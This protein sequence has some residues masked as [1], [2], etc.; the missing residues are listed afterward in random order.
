[1]EVTYCSICEKL[2]LNE[3]CWKYCDVGNKSTNC[4]FE[5]KLVDNIS[6]HTFVLSNSDSIIK[7]L[8]RR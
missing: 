3:S 7:R 8:F 5:V 4:V 1:M 2:D 6:E